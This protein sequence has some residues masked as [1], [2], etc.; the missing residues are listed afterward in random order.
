MSPFS[1]EGHQILQ[2]YARISS[3][4]S[5]A[6]LSPRS[7]RTDLARISRPISFNVRLR[8]SHQLGNVGFGRREGCDQADH[9]LAI[10]IEFEA[11]RLQAVDHWIRQPNEDFVRV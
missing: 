8:R 7:K 10:A 5:D 3:G 2:S 11:V 4:P 1:Q 9:A 6:C